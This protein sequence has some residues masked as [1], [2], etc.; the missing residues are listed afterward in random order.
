MQLFIDKGCVNC[1]NGVAVGG[2]SHQRFGAINDPSDTVRPP[3]DTG[4]AKVTEDQ[5]DEYVFKVPSLRNI[6]QTGPYFHSGEVDTLNEAVRIMAD[7]QLG[8]TLTDYE[9]DR[10]IR[11]LNTLTGEK[12]IIEYPKLP[13]STTDTP[14]PDTAT[15]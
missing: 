15:R 12:P 7:A 6:S 2:N 4:R 10:I 14:I 3:E 9:V 11:F 8:I 1:H 13:A 5:A